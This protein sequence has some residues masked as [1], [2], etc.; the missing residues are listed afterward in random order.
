MSGNPPPQF[1]LRTMLLAVTAFAVL[2]S[3]VA[4]FGHTG[5][6]GLT[7]VAVILAA[8]AGAFVGLLICSYAGL[9][10]GFDD[11]KWD[12]LKCVGLAAMTVLT[13]YGLYTWA[14][15]W[16]LQAISILVG[17]V[18]MKLFW[19][20][21]AGIEMLIVAFSAISA[22]GI[23]ASLIGHWTAVLTGG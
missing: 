3:L 15:V 9:G 4:V 14:E 10:F 11:L 13:A 19:E 5:I 17:I 18:S 21:I 22:A 12:A 2:C 8:A 1:S 23:V 6:G 7:M 16:R 20:D